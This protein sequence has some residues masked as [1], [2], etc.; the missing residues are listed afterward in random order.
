MA[1]TAEDKPQQKPTRKR[2]PRK[3]T[4]PATKTPDVIG[5]EGRAE[6]VAV[7]LE[8][9][10]KQM[11]RNEAVMIVNEQ[12]E[13]DP[14]GLTGEDG[15]PVSF[16]SRQATLRAAEK[17]LTAAYADIMPAVERLLER[18]RAERRA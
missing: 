4:V 13:D 16:K 15:E 7:M 6:V 5:D 8:D 10:Q 14:C 11:A 9:L 3:A 2:A 17:R 12:G 18:L 1:S